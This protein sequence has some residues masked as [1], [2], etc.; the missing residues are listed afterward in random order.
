[1]FELGP[2]LEDGS[3]QLPTD[4]T[5]GD[6]NGDGKPDVAILNRGDFNFTIDGYVQ[7]VLQL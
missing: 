6:F 3:N 1:V 4:L 2:S 7:V 5:T